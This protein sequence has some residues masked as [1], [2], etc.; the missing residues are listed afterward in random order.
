MDEKNEST[1]SKNEDITQLRE[2]NNMKKFLEAENGKYKETIEKITGKFDGINITI[3]SAQSYIDSY[4]K[5][6]K[7]V[8]DNIEILKLKK[9]KR[10]QE[11]ND[12]HLRISTVK[13]DDQSSASLNNNLNAELEDIQSEKDLILKR[14]SDLQKGIKKITTKRDNRL[15]YL[16]NCNEMLKQIYNKFRESQNKMEVSMIFKDS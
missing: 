3:S 4:K 16:K 15:P 1:F 7:K 5:R 6:H 8:L 9:E 10:I 13:E 14:L 12:L 11:V 2:L